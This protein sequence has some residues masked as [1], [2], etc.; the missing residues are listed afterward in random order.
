[1]VFI[2]ITLLT[3]L[4]EPFRRTIWNSPAIFK[5]EGL[6]SQIIIHVHVHRIVTSQNL[7]PAKFDKN[8][9]Q[10]AESSC[11]SGIL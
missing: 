1:M 8:F 7:V 11:N 6:N 2:G 4:L 9:N 5:N 3:T 10:N